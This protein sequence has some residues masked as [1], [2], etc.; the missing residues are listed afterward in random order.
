MK[1]ITGY[2]RYGL[3]LSM[4][5][6]TACKKVINVDLK[7]AT[8]QIVIEGN[9]TDAPSVYTVFISKTVDFSADNVFPPVTDAIVTITDSTAHTT[10]QLKGGGFRHLYYR[11]DHRITQPYLLFERV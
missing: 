8:P 6:I 11:S 7:N 3:L 4:L 10:E 5:L 2:A 9:I 1:P